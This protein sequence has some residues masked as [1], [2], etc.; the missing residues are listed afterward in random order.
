VRKRAESIE[1][2]QAGPI[3]AVGQLLL[4]MIAGIA[5]SKQ[6]LLEWVHQVGLAALSEVFEYDAEQLA[7]AKGK[8]RSARSHYR[9]GTTFSELPFGGRRVKLRRP[10]VRATAGAEARLPSIE[11]FRAADQVPVRVLNQILLGVSTRGYENSLDPAPAGIAVR[12]ASKSAASRHLVARM[13]HKMRTFLTRRLDDLE[14]LVLMLDGLHIAHHTVVVALGILSDGRKVVLGLWQGS[15][16][17]AVLCTALL[18]D[19]L[20]RGLKVNGQVLCVIDGGRG[21]RRALADVLGDLALVQRCVL[22]KKRNLLAHLPQTR[23]AHVSRALSEAWSSDSSELA[24]RRLKTLIQWLERNGEDGAAASLRE[25]MEETL[26]VLKLQLPASLRGFLLT[27]NAIE[28]LIG[29][30]RRLTRNVT[31]WRSGDMIARWS[32]TAIFNAEHNFRRV[33]GYR[34]LPILARALRHDTAKIDQ[35]E[36]AA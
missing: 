31:R 18:Q 1:A 25:G 29:S 30:V 17:N 20:G 11:H 23:H 34:Y 33:R 36:Q 16:E 7:G 2:K 13:T 24:R 4:P 10:R 21:L 5:R 8:H 26:T 6:A 9:W 22:H 3:A 19:L 15:T 14:L 28:N 12:G 35:S 32:A 27:T